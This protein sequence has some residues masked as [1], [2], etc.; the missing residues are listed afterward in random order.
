VLEKA[1]IVAVRVVFVVV[2]CGRAWGESVAQRAMQAQAVLDP[3]VRGTLIDT[4]KEIG[5][6]LVGDE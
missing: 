3:D 2:S 4:V 5:K 1:A 6:D